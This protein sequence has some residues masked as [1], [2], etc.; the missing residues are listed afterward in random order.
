MWADGGSSGQD[1]AGQQPQ[2]REG[3]AAEVELG[4]AAEEVLGGYQDVNSLIEALGLL[5][6]MHATLQVRGGEAWPECVSLVTNGRSRLIAQHTFSPA[7]SS[8]PPRTCPAT[9]STSLP[10]PRVLRRRSW[11]RRRLN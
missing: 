3:R 8:L 2:S 11:G 1:G 4:A 6:D 7:C 9:G 5:M 10:P